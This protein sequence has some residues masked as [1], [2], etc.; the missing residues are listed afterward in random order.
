MKYSYLCMVGSET[1]GSC[2]ARQNLRSGLRKFTPCPGSKKRTF[3]RGQTERASPKQE[4]HKFIYIILLSAIQKRRF[5]LWQ[6]K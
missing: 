2:Q 4:T 3:H 5:R 6:W 1:E